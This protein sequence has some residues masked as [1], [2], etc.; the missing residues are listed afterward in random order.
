MKKNTL[1][2]LLFIMI[3]MTSCKK[4]RTCTCESTIVSSTGITGG[5]GYIDSGPFATQT[6]K[7]IMPKVSKKTAQAN[8]TSNE[9]TKTQTETNGDTKTQIIK[10]DC[11]LK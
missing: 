8:C 6:D 5:I 7:T 2:A 4:E 1:F 3:V 10:R 9:D 11:V